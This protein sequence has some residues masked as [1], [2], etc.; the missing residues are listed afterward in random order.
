[1]PAKYD[2][3]NF[4]PPASVAKAA[5][6][7]LK[8]RAKQSKSNQGGT[9]VGLARANQLAKRETLSAATVKRMKAF[10]DRHQKN[11][12]VDSGKKAGADKGQQAWLLWGGDAGRAWA[13]K[14]VAQ[15]EKADSKK[16]VSR[17]LNPCGMTKGGTFDKGNS[18]AG[19]K[20]T[21]KSKSKKITKA[22]RNKA[23]E[24][25]AD[26]KITSNQL[27]DLLLPV[28]ERKS[29]FQ[30]KKKPSPPTL[31]KPTTEGQKEFFKDSKVRDPS[32]KLL[33]VFHG[34]TMKFDVFTNPYGGWNMFSDNYDYS[35]V[36]AQ[37]SGEVGEYYLNIK[38][39]LDLRSLP[40]EGGDARN[41]LLDLLRD[42]AEVDEDSFN[43][44][45]DHLPYAKDA[46]TI[47]NRSR[48]LLI[49]IL[50]DHGYDGIVMPD[51]V[52]GPDRNEKV[53]RIIGDTYIAFVSQQIKKVTN[54]NPTK[55]N[56]IDRALNPCGMTE[57][58]TFDKGNSCAGTKG[59]GKKAKNKKQRKVSLQTFKKNGVEFISPNR[60]PEQ[61]R[62]FTPVTGKN[63]DFIGLPTQEKIHKYLEKS[64][65][66]K[67]V[68][69][70]NKD[71]T[72]LAGYEWMKKHADKLIKAR[73]DIPT[74]KA[75]TEQGDSVYAVTL[76]ENDRKQ[77]AGA[78][79][80]MA[81]LTDV[82]FKDNDLGALYIQ[83]KIAGKT[84]LAT[85]VGTLDYDATINQVIPDD[86]DSWTPVGYNPSHSTFFYDKRTGK[87]VTGGSIAISV[88][89]TV[90]VKNPKY[91]KGGR[92]ALNKRESQSIRATEKRVAKINKTE[93]LIGTKKKKPKGIYDLDP[94][95]ELHDLFVGPRRKG[96]STERA[97]NSCGMTKGGTFDKG[98]SCAGTKGTGK[99]KAKKP[100]RQAK[101]YTRKGWKKSLDAWMD[102]NNLDKTKFW[103]KAKGRVELPDMETIKAIAAE[104]AT[105]KPDDA[106]RKSYDDF[107][108]HLMSQYDALVDSG[109]VVK[110]WQGEGE[111]YKVSEEKMWVPSSKKMRE[112]VEETGVFYFF[113]TDKGFGE[114]KTDS[115]HPFLQMSTA[116]T[117]DGEPM[118]YNDVF[119]VVHDA[120]AHLNGG[121]S[122]ST[123][124]EMN[125][126]LA[127][128]ST[129]P[130]ETW[131]ALW[132]ETFAQNAYYEVNKKFAPQNYFSSQYVNMIE[133]LQEK[134]KK[135]TEVARADVEIEHDDED[136]E[137]G[138]N[139][140]RRAVGAKFR[141]Y[142]KRFL[143]NKSRPNIQRFTSNPAA[144]KKKEGKTGG[145]GNNG[146]GFTEGN[147]CATG[148]P[149]GPTTGEK[150]V[151]GKQPFKNDIHPKTE[152]HFDAAW[153]K[154]F[155][156]KTDGISD[157]DQLTQK[158]A[159]EIR[160]LEKTHDVFYVPLN[161]DGKL[162]GQIVNV[163]SRIKLG[164]GNSADA[165]G[166]LQGEYR[167]E[168]IKVEN[169]PLRDKA[170]QKN[171]DK[172]TPVRKDNPKRGK[173]FKAAT[174]NMTADQTAKFARQ[175]LSPA[176]LSDESANDLA[177]YI[178]YKK[179]EE[180]HDLDF[181]T[182]WMSEA[183][184][185]EAE[186]K[187]KTNDKTS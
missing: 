152:K 93:K 128:A 80:P 71:G 83:E 146:Q 186:K 135:Q 123:R 62:K 23:L 182:S 107:K 184:I 181:M 12:K 61:Y 9:A 34:T 183:E 139:R 74:Y 11:K 122:F 148:S 18:C 33:K 151:K 164:H 60:D 114:G 102:R 40:R 132:A 127:H 131:P 63:S 72:K 145:C 76:H 50:I 10:F 88:G 106:T 68:T 158:I 36:F 177:K 4:K 108:K 53:R 38:R 47:I 49:E 28:E 113:M 167:L 161:K 31:S 130:K 45:K 100:K 82:T 121:Y 176:S 125:A 84:P 95:S 166:L 70:K 173:R 97:L 112:Q 35:Y 54:E 185:K 25:F 171:V 2:H 111:P 94:M 46:F 52:I 32:G 90:F 37:G 117:A 105:G 6:R 168:F 155:A 27:I 20:G 116:K 160:K 59:T 48:D 104:Q 41:E 136:G 87:E 169:S 162:V 153:A 141:Y 51:V 101:K 156:S 129:L 134:A 144:K 30:K 17:A 175:V 85:V 140:A 79:I 187:D 16:P 73:I 115:D 5:K 22:E 174:K 42:K 75:S 126:M 163:D 147:T 99:A 69:G 91:A 29:F 159:A 142:A 77:Y 13:K 21:G 3:I 39:P 149:A 67:M 66:A 133:E 150:E 1:M 14:V 110:A 81:V 179:D 44:L 137:C 15:M 178:K 55:A 109:L 8:M 98:N 43:Y 157:P 138:C 92:S 86:I 170:V 118:L 96:V 57:G 143:A 64:R 65:V 56:E 89:N 180:K 172:M 103:N 78:Y 7:G 124:G 165:M 58:G 24:D 154:E 19:T 26:G 120:V 119:R